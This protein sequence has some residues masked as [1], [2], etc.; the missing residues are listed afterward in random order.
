MNESN[1]NGNYVVTTDTVLRGV[2]T[3]IVTV[4]R[5][6]VLTNRGMICKDV[7]V[8]NGARFLNRSTVLGDVSGDGYAEI[9]GEVRGYVSSM[10]SSYIHEG[11]VINCKRYEWD[12]KNL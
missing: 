4:K 1:N 5:G 3:D 9:W 2:V 6:A 7:I 11:A 10:L 8:E 12:E